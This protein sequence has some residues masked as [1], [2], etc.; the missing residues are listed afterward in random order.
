MILPDVLWMTAM[1]LATVFFNIVEIPYEEV[2][3]YR[4]HME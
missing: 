3:G 1:V 2:P 4:G